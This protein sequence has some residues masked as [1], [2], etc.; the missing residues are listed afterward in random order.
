MKFCAAVCYTFHMLKNPDILERVINPKRGT[1]SQDLAR[2]V[3]EFR[4][5]R[6]DL[7]RYE[8]LSIK[9][10]AGTLT[11]SERAQLEDYVNVNDLLMILK[12]KAQASL[13]DQKPAA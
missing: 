9:A 10:Q 13:R 5:P 8:K 3:L 6:K 11:V 1:F 7:A 2:Q 4:F 12:A